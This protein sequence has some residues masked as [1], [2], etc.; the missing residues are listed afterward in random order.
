V[1]QPRHA[2]ADSATGPGDHHYF[3]T[4][5]DSSF[6]HDIVTSS[7]RDGCTA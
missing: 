3:P 5:H 6:R 7:S 1:K 2:G 4:K